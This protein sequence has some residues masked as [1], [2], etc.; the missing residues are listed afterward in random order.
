MAGWMCQLLH[1]QL[2]DS[3]SSEVYSY[4]ADL[5]ACTTREHPICKLQVWNRNEEEMLSTAGK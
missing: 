5:F 3:T 2:C 4:I 1:G